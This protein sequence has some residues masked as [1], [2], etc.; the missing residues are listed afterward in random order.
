MGLFFLKILICANGGARERVVAIHYS[1][2]FGL[3][4]CGG[5]VTMTQICSD[6]AGAEEV[7][8]RPRGLSLGE[9][10]ILRPKVRGC[11]RVRC[12][13]PD[14]RRSL[15][16]LSRL[17]VRALLMRIGRGGIHFAG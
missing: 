14:W 8:R 15:S 16:A 12:C 5:D 3:P 2:P 9:R 4:V 11:F 7:G 17:F 13:C 6:G 1:A 10:I